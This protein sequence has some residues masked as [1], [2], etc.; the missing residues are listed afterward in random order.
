MKLVLNSFVRNHASAAL[1]L[2]ASFAAVSPSAG[3]KNPVKPVPQPAAVIAHLPLE[4]SPASQMFLRVQDG[5][6]Y[7]YLGQASRGGLSVIDVT[8]PNQPSLARRV[9]WQDDAF[10]GELQMVGSSLALAEAPAISCAEPASR[11][12]TLKVLDLSDPE[13]PRTI[14]SFSEVTST[15]VDDARNLV[16]ITNTRGLWIVKHGPE[17]QP[18][19]ACLSEDATDEFASC[20]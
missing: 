9:A 6:Q 3:A 17:Q 5:A 11:T 7:L 8:D 14:L 2:F 19:R 18:R 15:L 10:S 20:E 13:N 16:Y 4:G 1:A 12:G